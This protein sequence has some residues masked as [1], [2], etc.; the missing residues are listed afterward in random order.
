MEKVEYTEYQELIKPEAQEISV[1]VQVPKDD[2]YPIHVIIQSGRR[3][4]RYSLAEFSGIS[5]VVMK[6]L[7][8][9]GWRKDIK[10]GGEGK[11]YGWKPD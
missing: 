5:D 11:E 2:Q 1:L 10:P 6:A 9:A 7:E 4:L 3:W 8:S